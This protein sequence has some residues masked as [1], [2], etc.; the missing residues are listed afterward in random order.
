MNEDIIAGNW[1]QLRGKVQQK[2]GKL[3][4]DELDV[5]AGKKEELVGKIQEHYGQAKDEV[6]REVDSMW[7]DAD[8]ELTA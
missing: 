7:D 2:W 1:K 3:T 4:N 5:I 6:E 8:D